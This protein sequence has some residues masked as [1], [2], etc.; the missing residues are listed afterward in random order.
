MIACFLVWNALERSTMPDDVD[1][2]RVEADGN[3]FHFMERP[4][5]RLVVLARRRQDRKLCQMTS[6]RRGP[7]N[8]VPGGMQPD[9]HQSLDAWLHRRQSI[10]GIGMDIRGKGSLCALGCCLR[11][12]AD[13]RVPGRQHE[14]S[15]R[16][17]DRTGG[18]AHPFLL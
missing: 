17:H 3:R 16:E 4:L 7:A 9:R 1:S 10:A 8:V 11:R 12:Q 6:E 13:D 18:C 14:D 2:R 5:V 15:K